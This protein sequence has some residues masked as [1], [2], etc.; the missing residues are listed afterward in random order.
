MVRYQGIAP[1]SRKA[2]ASV[3]DLSKSL[4]NL[5]T[6]LGGEDAGIANV[7]SNNAAYAAAVRDLWPVASASRLILDHT[8]AFYVRKDERPRKGANKDEPRILCEVC[9]D[10]PLIRSEMDARKEMLSLALKERG[11]AFDEIRIIPAR[12]GMRQRHPFREPS[13]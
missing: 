12:R 2:N 5:V 4:A 13:A 1:S 7:M 8:N 11:L 10:E 6:S 3:K 9:L